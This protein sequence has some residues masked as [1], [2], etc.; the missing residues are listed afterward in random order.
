MKPTKLRVPA[1]FHHKAT[2]Q[3]AVCIRDADGKRRMIYL[4]RHGSPEARQRYG[5]VVGD[6]VAGRRV[7]AARTAKRPASVWPTVE[8]LCAEYMLFAARYYLDPD[9]K[10][11]GE[12]VH[13]TYAFEQLLGL[14]RATPTDQVTI[15]DLLA[16]RQALVDLR[17]ERE[18]GRRA[19][20]GLSR[21]TINDRMARIKRLFRWGVERRLVPG[22]TWH[23]LSALRG[24]PKGRS[25]VHDNAPV[26][27]VPRGMVDA[28]L[29]LLTPTI[30]AAVDVQWWTG[31]R[32]AEVLAMTRRQLDTTG[33]TWLYRLARHKGSWRGK[34][35]VVA[36]GPKAQEFLRPRLRLELDAPLFSGREAWAEFVAAKREARTS[37][38][39]KQTADRD[40]RAAE[41]EPVG[42]FLEV[43]EYRRAIHRACD[44]AKLPR[45]SPH[46][47]RHAA[48]TRIAQEVGIEAARAALGHSDVSTTRRYATGA[49]VEIAKATAAQLG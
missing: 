21:R 29:P 32:P 40:R 46:R 2:D 36:I 6:Y 15:A 5:E 41:R 17:P 13:A 47:L 39:T 42:E 30:A 16:V 26:E 4:G 19:P 3:D 14:H 24:L 22:A 33:K 10:P 43:D 31:M 12:V 11:T 27:A 34:E 25:G 20:N 35:R 28:I 48:G 45:W 23:E 49:D 38:P 7:E 37:E 9:G 18:R 44:K 1:L 8:Q